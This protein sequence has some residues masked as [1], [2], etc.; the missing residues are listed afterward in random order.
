MS[1]DPKRKKKGGDPFSVS[2]STSR[3]IAKASR[4]SE[5][6]NVKAKKRR[7]DIIDEGTPS[8]PRFLTGAPTRSNGQPTPRPSKPTAKQKKPK[9]VKRKGKLCLT[10][11]GTQQGRGR[12]TSA[13]CRN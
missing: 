6:Q 12:R 3:R 8:N 2:R 5:K 1:D 11:G 13:S 9:L 7:Q 4:K 10:K